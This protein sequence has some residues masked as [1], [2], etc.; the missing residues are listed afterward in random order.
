MKFRIIVAAAF[1]LLM[2]VAVL[3]L[4]SLGLL[5]ASIKATGQPPT[6][7]AAADRN[8]LCFHLAGAILACAVL[9]L[10]S[11]VPSVRELRLPGVLVLAAPLVSAALFVQTRISRWQMDE[12]LFAGGAFGV[13]IAIAT[14]IAAHGLLVMNRHQLARAR[15]RAV[16]YGLHLAA[17]LVLVWSLAFVVAALLPGPLN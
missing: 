15:A 11:T 3:E 2:V 12:L 6:G 5:T 9:A 14:T 16:R 4:Q 8:V 1:T 10:M 7:D 13:G 17:V